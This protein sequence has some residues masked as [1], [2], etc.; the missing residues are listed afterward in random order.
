MDNDTQNSSLLK[1]SLE[2]GLISGLAIVI[3]SYIFH[4]LG[5]DNQSTAQQVVGWILYF[6]A[7]F[8]FL[9]HY[10]DHRNNGA[11]SLGRAVGLGALSFIWIGVIVGLYTYALFTW[12]DPSLLDLIYEQAYDDMVEQGMAESQIEQAMEMSAMFMKPWFFLLISIISM[13]IIGVIVSLITGAILKKE[14]KI[15]PSLDQ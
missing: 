15:N 7:A 5:S 13:P 11:L 8:L 14:E 2:Y 10:R 6:A 1:N 3:I 9:K 12:I 4:L